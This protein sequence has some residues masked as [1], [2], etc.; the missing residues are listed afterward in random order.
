LVAALNAL[1]AGVLA[2]LLI[3]WMGAV[4]LLAAVAGGVAVGFVVMQ[5]E[6]ALGSRAISRLERFVT[7]R[8][9][10]PPPPSRPR[11]QTA[12]ARRAQP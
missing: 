3:S 10:S 4:P 2:G 7:P 8:F 6:A 11:R 12:A 9:P 1:V 5:I